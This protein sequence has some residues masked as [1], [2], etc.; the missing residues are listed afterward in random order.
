MKKPKNGKT[1]LAAMP[2]DAQAAARR[3]AKKHG[4][5][6]AEEVARVGASMERVCRRGNAERDIGVP[7][8]TPAQVRKAVRKLAKV[9]GC[10]AAQVLADERKAHARASGRG[11]L[12]HADIMGKGVVTDRKR[13]DAKYGRAAAE[14]FAQM[15]A[16]ELQRVREAHAQTVAE[17]AADVAAVAAARDEAQ[18]H[19]Y[20]LAQQIAGKRTQGKRKKSAAR[21][22]A[23]FLREQLFRMWEEYRMECRGKRNP[24][25]AGFLDAGFAVVYRGETRSVIDYL[26]TPEDVKGLLKLQRQNMSNAERREIAQKPKPGKK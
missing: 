19:A 21:D 18:A 1:M 20:R 7:K 23:P 22:F 17:A 24:T 10:S 26:K 13:L 15:Y 14:C 9:R 5:T 11:K 12:Y 3:L 4:T 6:P 25:Y 8:A 16:A 2:Q